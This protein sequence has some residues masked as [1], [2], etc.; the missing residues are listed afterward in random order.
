MTAVFISLPYE[1]LRKTDE[2]IGEWR[3]LHH[4]ELNNLHSSS[5]IVR[6]IKSRIM[7]WEGHV[8]LW[9]RGEMYVGFW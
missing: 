9:G 3:K 5:S 6:L 4:E 2:I 8:A 7:R 1:I